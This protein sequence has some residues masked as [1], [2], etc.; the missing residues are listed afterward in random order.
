[1]P[2]LVPVIRVLRACSQARSSRCR[3]PGQR[4]TAYSMQAT[5]QQE[6][7]TVL[8]SAQWLCVPGGA[9]LVDAQVWKAG[10]TELDSC[11]YWSWKMTAQ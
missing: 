3:L 4:S 9:N 2:A 10:T 5:D 8:C 11:V 1:M 7:M 6:S